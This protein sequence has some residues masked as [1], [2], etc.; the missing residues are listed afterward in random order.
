[1]YILLLFKELKYYYRL[2]GNL[3][4]GSQR[5]MPLSTNKFIFMLESE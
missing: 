4:R 3:K 1:M 5:A 2:D